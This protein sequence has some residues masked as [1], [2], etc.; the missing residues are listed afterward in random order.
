MPRYRQVAYSFGPPL[1]RVVRRLMLITTGAFAV[2][3]IPQQIF[4]WS[5]P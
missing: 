5:A 2:T 1:T 4:G 3:Y